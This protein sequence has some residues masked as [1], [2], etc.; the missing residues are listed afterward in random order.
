MAP[1]AKECAITMMAR[2]EGAGVATRQKFQELRETG[3]FALG[4][5]VKV[6]GHQAVGVNARR[7]LCGGHSEIGQKQAAVFVVAEC[8]LL[9]RAAVHNVVPLARTITAD[10]A[11]HMIV[12]DSWMLVSD[13]RSDTAREDIRRQTE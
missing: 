6:V 9:G 4:N 12:L 3:L 2:V 5:D 1:T 8:S 13:L 7:T 11:R 10:R